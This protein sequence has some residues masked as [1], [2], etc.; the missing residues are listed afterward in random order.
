M[1]RRTL[2]ALAAAAPVTAVLPAAAQQTPTSDRIPFDPPELEFVYEA[3]AEI[4][5]GIDLGK[6]PLGERR[7]VP[8]TGGTFEGP[9][10]RGT[11]VAGG[12]DRQLVR[13]DG[14]RLLDAFYEMKTDDG[15]YL[16][17][18]N[19]VTSVPDRRRFSYLEITAPEGPYDWMNDRIFVGTLDSLKPER[20]AV[21]IRVFALK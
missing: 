15:A 17:I 19:H 9:R 7:M 8:I 5:E 4:E 20:P 16:T 1:Q 13:P 3:I 21:V 18:R 11:V 12:I 10:L 2:L 14:V 6:G